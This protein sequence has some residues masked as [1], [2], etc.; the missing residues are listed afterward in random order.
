MIVM[1]PFISQSPLY[2]SDPERGRKKKRL[3]LYFLFVEMHLIAGVGGVFIKF[4]FLIKSNFLF[5]SQLRCDKGFAAGASHREDG[6]V[7]LTSSCQH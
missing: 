7:G 1:F 3:Q 6:I 4:N 2:Y 5:A